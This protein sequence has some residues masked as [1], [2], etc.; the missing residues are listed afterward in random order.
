[1]NAT[2]C[3]IPPPPSP[4]GPPH[5]LA[6]L[7]DLYGEAPLG[8][9]RRNKRLVEMAMCLAS[10]PAASIPRAF[11]GWA[12]V[13]GAYRAIE[14]ERLTPEHLHRAA[15]QKAAR[16]VRG[17]ESILLIQD[18]TSLSFAN[19]PATAGLGPVT[20]GPAQGLH[21]HSGLAVDTNGMPLGILSQQVW[22][23]PQ[24]P[25]TET[26]EERR[27]LPVEEKESHKWI[28]A[29]A[30]ARRAIR[31]EIADERLRPRLIHVQDREGDIHDVFADVVEHGDGCV[32]RSC[33]NRCA[34]GEDDTVDR[35]HDLVAR[36]CLLG[37]IEVVVERRGDRPGRRARVEIRSAALHLRPPTTHNRDRRGLAMGIVEAREVGAPPGTKEPI[38]WRLLTTEPCATFADACAVVAIY[39]HRWLIEEVHLVLKSGCKIEH[40]RLRTAQ[41]IE[42]MVALYTPVALILLQLREW[43]RQDPQA[44]CTVVLDA[45]AWPV[46]YAAV[47]HRP[48]PPDMATPTVLEATLWIGRLGGHLGRKGDGLPGIRVLWYG[49]RDLCRFA[50]LARALRAPASLP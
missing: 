2:S 19:A 44:P 25:R 30:Q 35:A 16:D 6:W 45:Q 50:Q 5:L 11:D 17:R 31:E 12:E 14:S 20:N 48:A 28:F 34:A 39:T 8:D 9:R 46:L 18:T 23:R 36:G 3:Q 40:L 4:A 21:V 27:R 1:M 42:K 49:W 41:R 47:H 10:D 38:H 33:Q 37:V 43:S 22:A 29:M 26:H 32:I 13:K 15:R 7:Q 24:E